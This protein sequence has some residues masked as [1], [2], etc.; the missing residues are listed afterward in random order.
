MKAKKSMPG[1]GLGAPGG[2][3]GKK[4]GQ[5]AVLADFGR[6]GT[7]AGCP[8]WRQDGRTWRQEGAK[9]TWQLLETKMAKMTQNK[10]T[11]GANGWL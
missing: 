3:L 8:K 7:G 5:E 1:G 9:M 10:R 11:W 4:N 6:F 2:D